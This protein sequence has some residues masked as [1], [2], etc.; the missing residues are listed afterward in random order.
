MPLLVIGLIAVAGALLTYRSIRPLRRHR[1]DY[2]AGS[3]SEYW[4][5][6]Q[7]GTSDDR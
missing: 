7:R 1:K 5:H 6:Q 3:V 4:L 2:D